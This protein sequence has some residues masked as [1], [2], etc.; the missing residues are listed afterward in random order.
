MHEALHAKDNVDRLC[1]PRKEGRGLASIKDNVDASIQRLE[2]FIKKRRGRLITATRNKSDHQRIVKKKNNI[3][4]W[5]D[6]IRYYRREDKNCWELGA[7][8]NKMINCIEEY[9]NNKQHHRE[10][11]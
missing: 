7:Q 5:R 6:C 11:E 8:N 9:I 10:C 2:D 1:V 3:Y 4:S